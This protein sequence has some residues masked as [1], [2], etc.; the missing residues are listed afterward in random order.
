MLRSP[1]GRPAS[2]HSS[3]RR[4]V[5]S[6]VSSEGLTTTVHPGPAPKQSSRNRAPV[7]SSQGVMAHHAD[8]PT[9]RVGIP[10]DNCRSGPHCIHNLDVLVRALIQQTIGKLRTIATAILPL[11]PRGCSLYASSAAGA[12]RRA[13][14]PIIGTLL[15]IENSNHGWR[16]QQCSAA[17]IK[18]DIP[19][20]GAERTYRARP[21]WTAA[22]THRLFPNGWYQDIDPQ[23]G[24]G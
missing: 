4:I 8:R 13:W 3:A 14:A 12:T 6:G 7:D 16:F 21:V 15:S 9:P 22:S 24:L 23:P 18:S 5:L 1:A 2:R 10:P 17:D 19:D 11:K 20:T